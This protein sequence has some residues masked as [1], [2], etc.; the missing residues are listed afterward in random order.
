[1]DSDVHSPPAPRLTDRE[2]EE[3]L[4]RLSP[5]LKSILARYRVPFQ[6]A[7]DLLQDALTLLWR[8]AGDLRDPEA[9]LVTTLQYRC[10]MYWRSHGRRRLEVVESELLEALAAPQPPA[11]ENAALRHDLSRELAALPPRSRRLV[12]L[13]YGLGLTVRE[14]AERLDAPAEAVRQRSIHARTLFARRL[15]R[16]NLI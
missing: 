12:R 7:E 8:K 11:Q 10:Q 6:D 16:H 5:R 15:S 2:L 14:A 13:R 9:Y 1:M 4:V 3:L